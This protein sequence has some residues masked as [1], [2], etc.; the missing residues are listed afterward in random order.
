[1]E[2]RRRRSR[3]GARRSFLAALESLHDALKLLGDPPLHLGEHG[4]LNG[5]GFEHIGFDVIELSVIEQLVFMVADEGE[6]RVLVLVPSRSR[7]EVYEDPVAG[8][9]V[10]AQ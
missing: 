6:L 7:L 4:R 9:A 5:V 1:M 8:I 2:R 10:P 3:A